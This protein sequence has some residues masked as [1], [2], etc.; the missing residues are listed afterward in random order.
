MQSVHLMFSERQNPVEFRFNAQQQL[1][2]W[3]SFF[4]VSLA[5]FK[6]AGMTRST[7][8]GCTGQPYLRSLFRFP[9][10]SH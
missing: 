8:S 2:P 6:F 4:E 5:G 1:P 7:N 3:P 9:A 10:A